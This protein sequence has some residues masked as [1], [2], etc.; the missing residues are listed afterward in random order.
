MEQMVV[1]VTMTMTMVVVVVMMVV[2]VVV[3][4]FI[5]ATLGKSSADGSIPI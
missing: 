5:G 4:E 2:V 3:V 1:M